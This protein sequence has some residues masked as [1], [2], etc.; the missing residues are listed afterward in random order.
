MN[1]PDF[2]PEGGR[3]HG[4]LSSDGISG[5]AQSA[6]PDSGLHA[7]WSGNAVADPS[8]QSGEASTAALVMIVSQNRR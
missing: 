2:M 8:L 7:R 4:V 3:Q 1:V 5:E 6:C